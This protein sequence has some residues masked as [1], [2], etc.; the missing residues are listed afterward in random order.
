M[1]FVTFTLQRYNK[2]LEYTSF[3]MKKLNLFEFCHLNNLLFAQTCDCSFEGFPFR[4][5]CRR[6]YK[7]LFAFF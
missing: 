1:I 3:L 5:G 2:Y 6:Y 7:F 4:V